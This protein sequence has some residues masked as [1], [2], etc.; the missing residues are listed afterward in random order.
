MYPAGSVSCFPLWGGPATPPSEPLAMNF[1][2]P[3]KRFSLK[4]PREGVSTVPGVSITRQPV[5]LRVLSATGIREALYPAMLGEEGASLGSGL[6][7]WHEWT[8]GS[9]WDT[10]VLTVSHLSQACFAQ[11]LLDALSLVSWCLCYF[12]SLYGCSI[13]SQHTG[14]SAPSWRYKGMV[15]PQLPSLTEAHKLADNWPPRW[16]AT[17]SGAC[18]LHLWVTQSRHGC[19]ALL[20]L[21]AE[22]G[23]R[24]GR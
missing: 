10:E 1:H 19:Q 9:P 8:R 3:G 7:D 16:E 20:R 14:S 22:M 11:V 4:R 2:V 12:T 6:T 15:A 18:H 21:F 17:G 24:L 5:F 23:H 13:L